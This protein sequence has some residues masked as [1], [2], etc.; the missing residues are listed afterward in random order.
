M[1]RSCLAISNGLTGSRHIPNV[2]RTFSATWL[3]VSAIAF[4]SELLLNC[5]PLCRDFIHTCVIELFGSQQ[6]ANRLLWLFNN[7]QLL[8]QAHE[9]S[10]SRKQSVDEVRLQ[11]LQ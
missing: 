9:V 1:I 11:A 2:L 3:I 7:W 10:W 5:P 8:R 6:P 4:L